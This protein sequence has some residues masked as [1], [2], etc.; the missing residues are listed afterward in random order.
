MKKGIDVSKW[1]DGINWPKV[2]AVGIEFAIIRASFGKDGLDK[3]FAANIEGA[4]KAGLSAGAYHYC[5]AKTVDEAKQEAQHFLDVIKGY[6]FEYPVLLDMEDR[7]Q[8]ALSKATVTDMAIAFMEVL[9]SAGYFTGMY[10]SKAFFT[11]NVDDSRLKP[12][13][14][15]VAQWAGKCTYAG[16]IG[17]WQYT[18]SGTVEGISGRVDMD[19][20]YVDYPSIIAQAGLNGY[21]KTAPEPVAPKPTVKPAPTPKVEPQ[22]VYIVKAGDTL[23][24]IATDF[25][26]P[27]GYAALAKANGIADPSKIFPGQ[28]IVLK[29]TSPK[30]APAHEYYTTVKGDN[31]W[32]IAQKYK[33]TVDNL[34]RLNKI[35]NPSM[36][37][38]GQ[39]IIIK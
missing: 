19:Y 33:T 27:G 9:E 16:D 7:E 38:P 17:I 37:Y 20:A 6:K 4:H 22:T 35:T 21:I 39:K 31:L 1:Q 26:Y 8:K 36:I 30:V 2:K 14:H 15:W 32:M 34:A 25:N 10:S 24:K 29:G 12:Y 23:S 5:Y 11:G 13:A 28:K 18:S 3:C